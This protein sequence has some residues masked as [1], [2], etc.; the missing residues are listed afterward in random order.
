MLK[1]GI[2]PDTQNYNILLRAARDCGIGNLELAS[3]LLLKRTEDVNPKL[4]SGRKSRRMKAKEETLCTKVLN[5]DAFENELFVDARSRDAVYL[6]AHPAAHG[7]AKDNHSNPQNENDQCKSQGEVQMLP[8]SPQ[9]EGNLLSGSLSCQSQLSPR[10]PNL[11]DPSPCHSDVVALGPVKSASDRLALIGNLDG[12]L[13]KMASDGLEPNIKT[14]T[15]LADVMEA[16]SQSVRSLIDV[17]K[18]SGIRLDVPFFNTLIRRVAKTGDLDGA[19][20]R[21]TLNQLL[22]TL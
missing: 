4:T 14:I 11:L 22:I 2:K 9:A 20:V 15:L 19:K 6:N 12:F 18:K 7:E 17:A 1:I 8:S 21:K 13:E 10:L 16:G 3:A 5:I